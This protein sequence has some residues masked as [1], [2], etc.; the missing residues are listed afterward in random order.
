MIKNNKG[1]QSYGSWHHRGTRIGYG[2]DIY[3]A[4][5]VIEGNYLAEN[6]WVRGHWSSIKMKNTKIFHGVDDQYDDI[7][8]FGGNTI[9][10]THPTSGKKIFVSKNAYDSRR[11]RVIIYNY[12]EDENVSVDLSSVLKV[13]EAYRIHSVFDL[14]GRAVKE[15]VYTGSNISIPM[16]TVKPPQPN[17]LNG[18]SEDDDPKKKFGVFIVTHAGC[19]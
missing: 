7:S 17:G 3:N 19:K 13:G 11:A 1:Y 2:G 4:D 18:I 8:D 12:D 5:A 14:F 15:G 9:L 6:F 10:S 16:G